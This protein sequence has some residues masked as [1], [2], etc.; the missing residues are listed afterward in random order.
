VIHS[1][2]RAHRWSRPIVR[3]GRALP[4]F[5][6]AGVG[7]RVAPSGAN[8]CSS[9]GHGDRPARGPRAI[10]SRPNGWVPAARR[11]YNCPGRRRSDVNVN[12]LP[13]DRRAHWPQR[14]GNH[15]SSGLSM[16]PAPY[17]QLG[18]GEGGECGPGHIASAIPATLSPAESR[19]ARGLVP[20]SPGDLRNLDTVGEDSRASRSRVSQ[21]KPGFDPS[22]PRRLAPGDR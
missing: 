12:A 20:A 5:T 3:A 8:R 2:F 21:A 19:R 10:L 15:H 6:A 1:T 11:A 18:G 14:R 9:A 4:D 13:R 22:H 7:A 17:G 16:A